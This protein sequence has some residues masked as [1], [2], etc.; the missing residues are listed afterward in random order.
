MIEKTFEGVLFEWKSSASK[1]GIKNFIKW[2][3]KYQREEIIKRAVHI[4]N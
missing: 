1:K 4:S 2:E 3:E